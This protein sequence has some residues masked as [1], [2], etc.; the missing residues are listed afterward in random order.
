M[1]KVPIRI[2]RPKMS[3]GDPISRSANAKAM[4]ENAKRNATSPTDHDPS[5][6]VLWK[7]TST[8]RKSRNPVRN[9][10][11]SSSTNEV[12]YCSCD[13]TCAPTSRRHSEN[14]STTLHHQLARRTR[15]HDASQNEEHDRPADLQREHAGELP[16]R[17][18]AEPDVD[19]R[20]QDRRERQ[21]LREPAEPAREVRDRHDHPREEEADGQRDHQHAADVEDPE[22]RQVV[23][24]SV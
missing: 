22:R 13:R 20:L 6:C 11:T 3:N 1:S 23:E 21:H 8:A 17:V 9:E 2:V 24:K 12:R 7:I 10:P 15:Q 5:R 14:V 19:R 4:L 18:L 16:A